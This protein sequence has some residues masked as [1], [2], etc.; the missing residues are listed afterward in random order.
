MNLN[1][2]SRSIVKCLRHSP[3]EWNIVLDKNG[4][5]K[6]IDILDRFNISKQQLEEIVITN[7]KKRLQF[8]D[9]NDLIRAAQGHSIDINIENSWQLVTDIDFLYHGTSK[10]NL[11]SI[12]ANGLQKMNRTH[13]HLSKTKE[14]AISVGLR[15]DQNPTILT[16]DSK[17]MIKSGYK[18]YMS[19]NGVYLTDHVPVR[20]IFIEQKE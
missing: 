8:S 12:L 15:K 16:I 1:K 5:A 20:Y 9:N 17:Q 11:D 2:I 18:I 13:V 6:T 3:Q 10:Q 19:S 7:D 4:W 14:V